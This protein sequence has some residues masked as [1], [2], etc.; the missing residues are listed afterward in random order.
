MWEL[1]TQFHGPNPMGPGPVQNVKSSHNV[2]WKLRK[3][4]RPKSQKSEVWHE[5]VSG[6]DWGGHSQC[7][8]QEYLLKQPHMAKPV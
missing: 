5:E 1:D 2:K 3:E 7:C 8:C 6:A 4:V